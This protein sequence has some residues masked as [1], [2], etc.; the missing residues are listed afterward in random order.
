M[1]NDTSP[2]LLDVTG[3]TKAFAGV[4]AVD[5]VSFDVRPGSIVGLIGPNGSGKSTTIDCLTGFTRPD[6]GLA[7]FDGRDVTGWRPEHL[8]AA[9]MVRTFQNVRIYEG[10]SVTDNLVVAARSLRRF[11]WAAQVLKLPRVTRHE[12]E[13][14][15]EALSHLRLVGIEKYAEAPAGILSYGQRKLVAFAMCLMGRPRL[16]ILDEPLAGVNPTVIRRIS[17]LIDRLNAEGQTFLLIEHN[18][19]FIMRHCDKVIVLEQGRLL[20]EGAPAVIRNDPRVLEAYL[21]NYA[22]YAEEEA[23]HV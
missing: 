7:R 14:R 10:M 3:L 5:H 18:V 22:Q 11:T 12:A 17:D 16:I 4:T 2:P 19:D 21:G 6:S 8:A 1:S 13:L 23:L 9:G 20:T 15:D